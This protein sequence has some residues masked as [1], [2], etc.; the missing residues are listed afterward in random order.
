M[1]KM[2]GEEVMQRRNSGDNRGQR[3]R[4]LWVAIIR[5]V[6]FA[7]H[8]IPV[9]LHVKGIL[10]LSH[11]SADFDP[12][13]ALPDTI[14]LKSLVLEPA[15]DLCDVGV[16]W[17]E[18]LPEFIRVQPVMVVGRIGIVLALVEGDQ[19]SFLFWTALEHQDHALKPLLSIQRS[20]VEFGSG[21]GMGISSQQHETG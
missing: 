3:G 6:L 11:G 20:A 9:H 8:K 16:G 13:F 10:N 21:E 18:K 2:P 7:V 12:D 14:E 17:P 15:G 5:D 1:G 4:N 19:S